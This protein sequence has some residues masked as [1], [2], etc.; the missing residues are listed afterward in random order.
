MHGIMTARLGSASLSDVLSTLD[1][2]VLRLG[3]HHFPTVFVL[4]Q[5]TSFLA[6][7]PVLT[8]VRG[9]VFCVRPVL[10]VVTNTVQS[11]M[12]MHC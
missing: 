9:F 4:C 1:L 10:P 2:D 7:A 11:C 12:H 3:L 6:S 8:H 5:D